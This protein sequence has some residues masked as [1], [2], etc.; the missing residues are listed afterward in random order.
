MALIIGLFGLL[1]V[2]FGVMYGVREVV[3]MGVAF[4]VLAVVIRFLEPKVDAKLRA[5]EAVSLPLPRQ[6][7]K[8]RLPYKVRGVVMLMMGIAWTVVL[9]YM[10]TGLFSLTGLLFVVA[11]LLQFGGSF[12]K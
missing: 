6:L 9:V 3:W 7:Y 10:G 12:K 11:G 5:M 1:E 4:V 8:K 2:F